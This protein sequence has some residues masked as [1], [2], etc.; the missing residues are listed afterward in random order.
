MRKK[1]YLFALVL[2]LV[3]SFGCTNTKKDSE[4]DTQTKNETTEESRIIELEE[5]NKKLKDNLASFALSL[6]ENEEIIKFYRSTFSNMSKRDDEDLKNKV[7][8][9]VLTPMFSFGNKLLNEE[10]AI[11][12]SSLDDKSLTIH[13]TY[14]NLPITLRHEYQ[15]AFQDEIMKIDPEKMLEIKTTHDY[16]IENNNS[17]GLN[18]AAITIKDLELG[19]TISIVLSDELAKLCDY[20]SG[21]ITIN[22]VE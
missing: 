14:K 7:N 4:N 9:D 13:F 17:Y 5:E 19:D 21:S 16:S 6:E 18:D 11:S 8:A 2:C 22:I 12:I 20:K 1:I 15:L 10:E 3:M